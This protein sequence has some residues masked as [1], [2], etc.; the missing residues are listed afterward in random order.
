[1]NEFG[2]SR[3]LG[4]FAFITIY[5]LG[6]TI[7]GIFCSPISEVFGRRTI[8]IVAATAFGIS[9]VIVAVPN[10]VAGVFVGR[11][12][13]GVSASIPV[14][15]AFGNFSD[16]FDA[17]KR[18]WVVYAYTLFGMA[19][20]ALG[21]VYSS[22]VT[23]TLGWKWVHHI[24]AIASGISV[25]CCLFIKE[26]NAS[27]ILQAKAKVLSART[28]NSRLKAKDNSPHSKHPLRD[29]IQSN[30]YR[31]LTFLF[32]EPLVT[33][34]AI[35]CATAFGL[36]YGLT[37]SLTIV[38]TSPPFDNTFDET[39]SSLT[40]LAILVGELINIFPRFYDERLLERQRT[41][42][43]RIEPETKIRSFALACPTLAIGLWLFAWTIPQRVPNVPSS[44][45][46]LGLICIG[47]SANDFSYVLFG[48]ITDAYG[49]Y[50][51]SAVS[52]LST[53]R[54]LTAAIF[55][56][57]MTQMYE[58]LGNNVATSVLAAVAI[59]FCFTPIVFL[60]YGKRL[61]E[62]SQWAV[63][64]EDALVDENKHLEDHEMHDRRMSGERAGIQSSHGTE[65]GDVQHE[66][67]IV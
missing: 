43:R 2:I 29:F 1:M 59:L 9:S 65:P 62:K 34:C 61:R 38:Y 11:F 45:S 54:T 46:M 4:V 19:G 49:F 14:T 39:T 24:S 8:Y 33:L 23:L 67:S 50:A 51:A 10:H 21:P 35:L 64:G 53:A 60:R 22:F 55:P 58:G 16:M 48:Y 63:K 18:I 42:H 3:L 6:Q 41:L 7:G 57:F 32:T 40:F 56:L 66:R 52:S 15:V 20:L 36:I 30:L 12:F 47:F 44:I 25:V 37:E 13:Q 5:L 27:Q 28:G 26:S 17:D 31:P